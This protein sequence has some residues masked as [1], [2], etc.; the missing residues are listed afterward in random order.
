MQKPFHPTLR[1]NGWVCALSRHKETAHALLNEPITFTG[2]TYS[3]NTVEL[4]RFIRG[5]WFP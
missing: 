3:T 2:R 4:A 5:V 1:S